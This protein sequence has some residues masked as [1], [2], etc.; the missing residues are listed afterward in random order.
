MSFGLP[1]DAVE[2][3]RRIFSAHAPVERVLVYGSRAKGNSREGSDIDLV[4]YGPP[5]STEYSLI[6]NELDD[7]MLPWKIDLSFRDT[8]D[9]PALVE[10]IDRVG[11]VLYER[12]EGQKL[13]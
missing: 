5:D 9:N 8:I 10:H 3:I 7:L 2:R 12:N 11:K 4:M 6:V 1:D 13:I